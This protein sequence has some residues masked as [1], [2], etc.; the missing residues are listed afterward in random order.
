MSESEL[1]IQDT[2]SSNFHCTC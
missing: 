2:I 1:G